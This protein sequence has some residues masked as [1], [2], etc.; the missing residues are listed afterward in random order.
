M[1]LLDIIFP[2]HMIKLTSST[3]PEYL[4]VGQALT[5]SYPQANP[6][7]FLF[8]IKFYW[9]VDIFVYALCMTAFEL[10]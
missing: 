5:K 6:S 1:V 9:N 2:L 10:R 7:S 4:T 8:K 3:P